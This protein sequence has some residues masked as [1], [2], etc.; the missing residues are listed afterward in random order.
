LQLV[1]SSHAAQVLANVLLALL[2]LSLCAMAVLPWQ[3]SARGAGKVVAFVP[4]EREQ[5][6]TSPVKGVVD[7]LGEGLVE[8]AVVKRGQFILEIEPSAANLVEQLQAQLK[9]LR[10]KLDS[11]NSKA[12]IYAANVRDF[13]EVRNFAI[14]AAEE[15]VQAA[16]AKLDAKQKLVPG[17]EA[18][19]LQARLNYERQKILL[20]KGV[21]SEKEV[22]YLKKDWDVAKAELESARLEA[23][24]AEQE[25][26]AKIHEREQKDREA[27]TKVDYARAMREDA[28][29]Q[30]AAAQKE[31]RDVEVKLSEMDRLVINAP[32]DGTI[33]R[34]PVFERGQ[35]LKE[36]DTLFTIVPETTER[37]VELWVS[38]NDM[39][40]IRMNDHVRLQF[41]G[42]P[43]VQFAGWPSVAVGTF[44]GRIVATDA[45]DDG[46]G[47]FRVL[48]KQDG[49]K[50]WPSERY[51]RQGVRVNGWVM[52]SRVRLGYEIWRQLNGFPPVVAKDEPGGG[53]GD[54]AK[55]KLPK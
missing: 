24:A 32:R 4:Q 42:W 43:A 35:M 19:E 53:K 34:M 30:A 16:K 54:K 12:E 51:L 36:G 2:G 55:V 6:V 44:G 31:I 37:A 38:G 22:E 9:D 17:Y 41:E 3:Q 20:E 21:K 13:G 25:W 39:P 52:L 7:R 27:Q 33:F 48:V 45:T 23:T 10:A 15:M 5:T 14:S 18:K 49:D 28:L 26:D 8:G 40:L 29:G 47:K 1:Q 46:A 11:S 50:K